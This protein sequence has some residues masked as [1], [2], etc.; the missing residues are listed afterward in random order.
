M[1]TSVQRI[2]LIFNS[3]RVY[4]LAPST[5][6]IFN[7]VYTSA[8]SIKPDYSGGKEKSSSRPIII[9]WLVG[10]LVGWFG[11][12]RGRG[13]PGDGLQATT[14][15]TVANSLLAMS[16]PTDANGLLATI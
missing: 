1:Y 16:D 14:D 15:P 6:M 11:L 4:T 10:W 7:S 2:K 3:V 5:K 12:N 9:G 8:P 13:P